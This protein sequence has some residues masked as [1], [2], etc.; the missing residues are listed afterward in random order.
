MRKPVWIEVIVAGK[1]R[2]QA[3]SP[4]GFTHL[5]LPLLEVRTWRRSRDVL[6][7]I[8]TAALEVPNWIFPSTAG[9]KGLSE[10]EPDGLSAP[11]HVY[12]VGHSTADAL[13]EAGRADVRFPPDGADSEALLNMLREGGIDGQ[14][15]A[16]FTA[17]EGRMW[18]N[19][20]LTTEGGEVSVVHVYHRAETRLSRP[21]SE[22]WKRLHVGAVYSAGSSDLLALLAQRLALIGYKPPYSNALIVYGPR[23][24]R[25]AEQL[26][27][28]HIVRIDEPTRDAVVVAVAAL[29]PT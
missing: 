4:A 10:L 27:F 14:K 20:Q 23:V 16:I 3:E 9:V 24:S 5:E 18:L 26:G 15:F 21:L 19:E 22:R 17:P 28:T 25:L 6:Q 13:V 7:D 12:A 8:A 11:K 29:D 2:S 1:A